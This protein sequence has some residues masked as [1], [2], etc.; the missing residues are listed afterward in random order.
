VF[1][2]ASHNP[3]YSVALVTQSFFPLQN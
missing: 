3:S 1:K 2:N